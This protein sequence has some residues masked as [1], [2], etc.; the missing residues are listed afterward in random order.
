[1]LHPRHR[2]NGSSQIIAFKASDQQQRRSFAA[3]L[4]LPLPQFHTPK[5]VFPYRLRD[6]F[7][8]NE[9]SVIGRKLLELLRQNFVALVFQRAGCGGMDKKEKRRKQQM[10]KSARGEGAINSSIHHWVQEY[11]VRSWFLKP[12]N[13]R[14][15]T[16]FSLLV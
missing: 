13:F 2:A 7:Q 16:W 14:P 8:A 5:I 4:I 12:A 9:L 6:A 11:R 1:M 15:A 10:K 3:L